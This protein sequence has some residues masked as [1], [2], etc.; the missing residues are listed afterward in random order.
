MTYF[1]QRRRESFELFMGKVCTTAPTSLRHA[2][3]TFL[4]VDKGVNEGKDSQPDH[5]CATDGSQPH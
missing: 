5:D 3:N 4:L 2:T 1:S